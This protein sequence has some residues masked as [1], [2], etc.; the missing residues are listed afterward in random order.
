MQLYNTRHRDVFNY[1][2]DLSQSYPIYSIGHT[3]YAIYGK[4]LQ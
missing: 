1:L 4:K 3:R 2:N